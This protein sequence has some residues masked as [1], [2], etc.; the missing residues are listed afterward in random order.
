MVALPAIRL[1]PSRLEAQSKQRKISYETEKTHMFKQK[2][3]QTGSVSVCV[4]L[5]TGR[6]EVFQLRLVKETALVLQ[7]VI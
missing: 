1:S 2:N 6:R 4:C 7:E 3:L 5:C